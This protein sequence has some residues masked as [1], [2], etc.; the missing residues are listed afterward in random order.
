[1][2]S[3]TDLVHRIGIFMLNNPHLKAIDIVEYFES[4]G[5][6]QEKTLYILREIDNL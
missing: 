2:Q 4:V 6:P 3:D 1:M 5:I